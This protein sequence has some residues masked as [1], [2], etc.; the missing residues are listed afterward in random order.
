M[1]NEGRNIRRNGRQAKF[2]KRKQMGNWLFC[3]AIMVA[4]I[5]FTFNIREILTQLEELQIILYD[6]TE[7]LE[8]V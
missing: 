4:L 2:R 7:N 5:V 1:R 3:I 8:T 6:K